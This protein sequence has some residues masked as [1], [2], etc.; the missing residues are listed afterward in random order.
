MAVAAVAARIGKARCGRSSWEEG[1]EFWTVFHCQVRYAWT[2]CDGL[3]GDGSIDEV[4]VVRWDSISGQSRS[5]MKIQGR[6]PG[7]WQGSELR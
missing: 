5:S 2:I 6:D 4:E 1:S 7:S 3:G